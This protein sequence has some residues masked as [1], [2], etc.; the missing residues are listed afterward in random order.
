M[1]STHDL[2]FNDLN[3]VGGRRSQL[4]YKIGRLNELDVDEFVC[5]ALPFLHRRQARL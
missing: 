3:E 2:S 4:D 1:A 5:D